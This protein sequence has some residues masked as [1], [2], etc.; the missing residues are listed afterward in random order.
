MGGFSHQLAISFLESPRHP[1]AFV[2][3]STGFLLDE[4]ATE[5]PEKGR[6]I[7][8]TFGQKSHANRAP[9]R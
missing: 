3:E 5:V 9:Q 2:Q 1:K 4:E 7:T 6:K 8:G